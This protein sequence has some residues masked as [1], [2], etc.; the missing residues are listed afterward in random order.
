MVYKINGK[1]V[2]EREFNNAF[3]KEVQNYI[4]YDEQYWPKRE[5]LKSKLE[6]EKEI[7]LPIYDKRFKDKKVIIDKNYYLACEETILELATLIEENQVD[8][9]YNDALKIATAVWNA[10]Y[11]KGN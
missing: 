10:G 3:E 6:E 8:P 4:P 2:T 9:L 11:R 5:E 7:W 1:E